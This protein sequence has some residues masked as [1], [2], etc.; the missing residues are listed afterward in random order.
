MREV[1]TTVHKYPYVLLEDRRVTSTDPI[2]KIVWRAACKP[3]SVIELDRGPMI[4]P[5]H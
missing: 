1:N 2:D 4:N 5:F 3:A